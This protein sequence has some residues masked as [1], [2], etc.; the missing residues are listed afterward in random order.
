MAPRSPFLV[1]PTLSVNPD[2]GSLE[3]EGPTGIE[4]G[5]TGEVPRVEGITWAVGM[6]TWLLT[7][8]K[9]GLLFELQKSSAV[10][11]HDV[12]MAVSPLSATLE[13]RLKR[14]RKLSDITGVCHSV[15]R[16]L[17]F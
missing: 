12:P 16:E 5:L 3:E 15:A 9:E 6:V 8:W 11:E 4:F 13:Q 1:I 14:P 17:P 10:S 2:K 7:G